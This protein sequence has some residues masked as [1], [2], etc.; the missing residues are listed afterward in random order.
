MPFY[1]EAVCA[2]C[3]KKFKIDRYNDKR[4]KPLCADCSPIS[5]QMMD[6]DYRAKHRISTVPEVNSQN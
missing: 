2:K 1:N 4:S 5:E 6:L 3:G